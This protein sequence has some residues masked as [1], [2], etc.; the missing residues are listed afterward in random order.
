MQRLRGSGYGIGHLKGELCRNRLTGGEFADLRRGNRLEPIAIAEGELRRERGF[1]RV[2]TVVAQ[3][4]GNDDALER[5]A[6]LGRLYREALEF[7]GE[8]TT[9]I[10]LAAMNQI[11]GQLILVLGL[12]LEDAKCS[13]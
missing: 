7:G 9:K 5:I 1:Q 4:E 12:H 2:L 11:Y 8:A 3:R 10:T 6:P 13:R